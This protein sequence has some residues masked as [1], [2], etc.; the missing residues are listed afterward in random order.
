MAA[1]RVKRIRRLRFEELEDRRLLTATIGGRVW[2][3]LEGDATLGHNDPGMPGW[4]VYL[5]QDATAV[6]TQA[7]RPSL[8]MAGER[9]RST[10]SRLAITRWRFSGRP[11]GRSRCRCRERCIK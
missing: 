2:Y 4:K 6:G 3:D 8:P 5:D 1:R 11:D 10:I 9:T 7:K